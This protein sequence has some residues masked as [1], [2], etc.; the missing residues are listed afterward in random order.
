MNIQSP[1][2]IPTISTEG[3]VFPLQYVLSK[4]VWSLGVSHES[5]R[6]STYISPVNFHRRIYFCLKL[7]FIFFFIIGFSPLEKP[8]VVVWTHVRLSR[9]RVFLHNLPHSTT[10]VNIYWIRMGPLPS[11]PTESSELIPNANDFTA[12]TNLRLGIFVLLYQNHLFLILFKLNLV[13][14]QCIIE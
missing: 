6:M 10:L 12:V 8:S 5:S 3:P 11:A 14:T 7:L 13:N 2:C 9:V 4:V 1:T